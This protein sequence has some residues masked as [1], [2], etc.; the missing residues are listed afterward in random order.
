M[1]LSVLF[2]ILFFASATAFGA[3]GFYEEN[4][5]KGL[6]GLEA[7]DYGAA[8]EHFGAAL[9]ERADDFEAT[10][11]LGTALSLG[12]EERAGDVLKQA[13]RLRPEEP[14]AS[15]ELGRHYFGKSQYEEARDY[16]ENVV[17]LAPGTEISS[18]AQRYLDIIER[19]AFKRW[20]VDLRAG[21]QYDDNVLLGPEEAALPAGVSGRSDWRA[22]IFLMGQYFLPLGEKLGAAASYSFYQTLHADLSD[23]NSTVHEAELGALYK[24]A[25]GSELRGTYGF[26]HVSVGG[27]EYYYAHRVS[28]SVVIKEGKGF[29]TE[30]K[31]AYSD[32]TFKEGGIF[33]GN[34]ERTGEN[35]LAGLLQS[36]ALGRR[37]SADLGYSYDVDS[38]EKDY[39]DYKG[40]KL[41]LDVLLKLDG[42]LDLGL[43]G[44]YYKKDYDGIHP[45]SGVSR[46]DEVQT[47]MLSVKKR[48][49]KTH[50]VSAA[51][52]YVRN[53]SNI[54]G[55]DY[56]RAIT[57]L[58]FTAGF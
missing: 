24:I 50:S 8:K 12:G 23:Y 27:D 19:K 41:H 14:R 35:H 43:Y 34:S 9:K 56:E 3:Q 17:L 47:Y 31:Y 37:L 16:F 28:P 36:I 1:R 40:N 49:S 25:G 15:L 44:E 53:K 26:R 39:W 57:S 51:Q 21:F 20:A 13:L 5:K 46:E 38:A 32:S 11:G 42:E 52:R 30:V 54:Y 2:L 48:L 33:V 7:K 58:F 55:Y 10:L 4:I 18:K 22:V 6:S 45:L 29:S